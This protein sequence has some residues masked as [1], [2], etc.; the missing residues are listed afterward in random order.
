M[1]FNN[2]YFY[3]LINTFNNVKRRQPHRNDR[4]LQSILTASI[5]TCSRNIDEQRKRSILFMLFIYTGVRC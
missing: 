4:T 2:I 3:G 1:V 5:Y